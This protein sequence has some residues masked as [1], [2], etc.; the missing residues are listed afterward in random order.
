MKLLIA[1]F[2]TTI[3]IFN[4]PDKNDSG[5]LQF[6]NQSQKP[7]F[8]FGIIADVQYCEYD[9]AGTRFYRSSLVKLRKA[10]ASLKED[11]ADFII[12]LGDLIDRDYGSFKPVLDIIDSS[13]LKTYHVTGNH[14][15][16]V[17]PRFKKRLPV[18]QPSKE[19]YYSFVYEKFRFIF[20]NGNEI[21]TYMS[22]NKAAIKQAVDFIAALKNKGEINA[23]DWNGGISSKQLAWLS[24]QLNEA[25]GKNEKV[26]LICHFPVVPDNVHNLLNYKEVFP[27][28]E[29][30]QNIIA[31]FNGHNHAGNYGN[32]NMIHF[33][34]F[35]GMVETDTNNS[36]ALV[37]VYKNK[38][39]IR[40]YGREK[41]QI[42]AY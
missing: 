13:G 40:G 22:N 42:L 34:T 3:I 32:F 25:T 27:I 38:I 33:V 21:S 9:P 39:W 10:V 15:Y 8:T 28:L 18:L 11:S 41:S 7:L 6:V 19:G 1:S 14:D 5:G 29:K 16:S 24:S 23:V 30:Y 17:D 20:L 36:F 26:F 37:E 31:W 12:N 2:F 35:K 4:M